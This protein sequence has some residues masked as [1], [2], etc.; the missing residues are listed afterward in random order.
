ILHGQW[1]WMRDPEIHSTTWEWDNATPAADWKR[2]HNYVHHTFTN[3]IGKDRDVGYVVL[4]MS[5]DQPWHPVYLLQPVTNLVLAAV[6]EYGIAIYDVELEK[7]VAGR[8]STRE[9]LDQ[10]RGV[11]RK[12]RSQ[13]VKDYVAFPLLS[14]PSAVPALLGNLT[15]NL[16]RNVWT[17]TIIF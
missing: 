1:D 13:L 16:A 7:I 5:E 3:V 14:G 17:H 15:A 11:W 4:R 8:K 2:S 9:A 12:V 10:L 6:F